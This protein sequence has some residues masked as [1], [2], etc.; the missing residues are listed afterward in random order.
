L[1][2]IEIIL[3][4]DGSTDNSKAILQRYLECDKR[5]ILISNSHSSGNSGIPRNQ[6]LARATGEFV[7]F[8]DSDDWIEQNMLSDLY[9]EATISC[10]D[11]VVSTGFYRELTDGTT[12]AVNTKNY[13]F[14]AAT[15][16]NRKILFLNPHF[17]IVWL[18]IYRMNFIREQNIKFG[19]TKTSADL[20]F[21]FKALFM[22]NSI[23]SVSGIY[24]HYRFDRPGSTIDKR[25]GAGAFELFDS[26]ETLVDFLVKK[27]AYEEF[28]PY[29]IHKAIGDFHYNLRF[30]SKEFTER[31]TLAMAHF[32][33][34]HKKHIEN[35]NIYG[36]K[37]TKVLKD[38]YNLINNGKYARGVCAD[39]KINNVSVRPLV[40]IIVPA[41]NSAT[42]IEKCLLSLMSQ[43]LTSIEIVVVND[44]SIDNTS[45]TIKSLMKKDRRIKLID[46]SSSSGSPGGAR[47][48]ALAFATGVYIGFVDSDDWVEVN[49]FEILYA[50]AK[51]I[52]ADIVSAGAF[53]REYREQYHKKCEK[54]IV[55][56]PEIEASQ[57]NHKKLFDGK[58][59]ANIWNR[60]YRREFIKKEGIYFP[61]IYVSEDLCFSIVAYGLSEKTSGVNECLYHWLYNRPDSTTER[62][63]GIIGFSAISNYH[64]VISYFQMYGLFDKFKPN[65]MHKMQNSLF[66]TYE[67]MTKSYQSAYLAEMATLLK[68]Y[69]N[70]FDFS[71]FNDKEL[72][73]FSQLQLINNRTDCL[74]SIVVPTDGKG[75]TE[76]TLLLDSESVVKGMPLMAATIT[77]PA[78]LETKKYSVLAINAARDIEIQRYTNLLWGGQQKAAVEQLNRIINSAS[79]SPAQRYKAAIKLGQWLAFIKD[80]AASEKLFLKAAHFVPSKRNSK[81]L[82][83]LL[84]FLYFSQGLND[85]A[86]AAFEII[87]SEEVDTDVILARINLIREDQARLDRINQ[88]YENFKLKTIE[89]HNPQLPLSLTNLC[90]RKTTSSLPDLGKV[91]V[92]MPVYC[93][94]NYVENA[95]RSV[96]NQTYHNLEIIIVDDCSTDS[97]FDLIKEIAQSD[98]RVIPVRMNQ[99]SGAYAARNHGLNFAS[100][101][102]IATHDSDDWSHPQKIEKQLEAL[103]SNSELMGVMTHWVRVSPDLYFTTGWRLTHN[104]IEWS[105]SSFLC[106]KEVH[107]Q[108][109]RWETVRVGADTEFISRV[110]SFYGKGSIR[111][112]L[113]SVPLAFALDAETTLTRNQDTHVATVF[114]GLR[115]YY[116]EISRYCHSN[117]NSKSSIANKMAVIPQELLNKNYVYPSCDLHITGDF[118]LPETVMVVRKICKENNDRLIVAVTHTPDS[119]VKLGGDKHYDGF[120]FCDQFFE[121]IQHP[122]IQIALPTAAIDAK[123]KINLNEL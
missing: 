61:H 26:Y 47:N 28:I 112:I 63:T 84:G 118:R 103:Y 8:V 11:I 76:R 31:F 58:Y 87:K 25:K 79:Y 80:F 96:C 10:A 48:L 66:Y 83:M 74:A 85:K 33:S 56:Y 108:L 42:Y 115:H 2:D 102:F 52:G 14:G 9:K 55:S 89:L 73:R 12:E 110:E 46:C 35:S 41:Y 16:P 116:R 57:G 117:A 105:H 17:P 20:P 95:I 37:N 43:S 44:G 88:V 119:K 121:L 75:T 98:S 92:I 62:R 32:V 111:K 71:L 122:R 36:E 99:N 4:D 45:Q 60:I 19:E 81:E 39:Q 82:G 100:G 107:E 40:S 101:A 109:G 22:A 91:S 24:Y 77:E 3:V 49:M 64:K 29:L 72:S 120:Q 15:Q 6:A 86:K 21:S 59:L 69:V 51:K 106:R 65:I 23:A 7:A 68:P 113:A 34:N 94:E 67:R 1:E 5:I 53:F 123:E 70:Y 78:C 27:G 90:A 50:K 38:L 54:V 93:A 97:T 30:L 13:N 104:I 114:F 18:R